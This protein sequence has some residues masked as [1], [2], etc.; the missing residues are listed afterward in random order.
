MARARTSWP[1][2][3]AL[4]VL[5]AGYAV[6]ECLAGARRSPLLPLLPRGVTA[7]GWTVRGARLLGLD[8]LGATALTA[9]GLVVMASLVAACAAAAIQAWRGR[10]AVAPAVVAVGLSLLLMVAG[11]VL[12]SRDVS[13]YAAY[14]RIAAVQGANP[15]RQTP[16]DFPNDPFVQAVSSEWIHSRSVYG[17]LFTLGSEAVVRAGTS[18][19][20]TVRWF[21]VLAAV[22]IGLA[23]WW[24]A[25]AA[26]VL[27]GPDRPP[28][29]AAAFAL[30]LVGLNPVLVVHTAGGAHNDALV[31][32]GLAGAALIAARRSRASRDRTGADGA[33][34]AVTAV[35]AAT[36]LIKVVAAIALVVW[37]WS[38][39]RSS[40]TPRRWGTLARHV[41][42]AV[43]LAVVSMVPYFDGWHTLGAFARLASRQ[44]WA[45]GAAMVARGASAIGGTPAARA[46]DVV[47]L[48]AFGWI[49]W[50]I[51]RGA[52]PERAPSDWAVAMLAFA[53]A[54]P[55]LLPWYAAWFV[56]L[57]AVAA[58]ARSP[59]PLDAVWIGAAASGVLALT[60]MPAEPIAGSGLYAHML[61]AV[62]Y[63]GGAVMLVLFVLLLRSVW[64]W[65]TTAVTAGVTT[66]S[67]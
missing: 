66:E 31:A 44:G 20:A 36:A 1:G 47:F 61:L 2:R 46:V 45:S 53:L 18:T 23:A 12:L 28:A 55:Y 34:L 25:A 13:S 22:G 54:A 51:L 58:S 35:L 60:G 26:R 50:R 9:V 49:L 63:A 17:P 39:V 27:A 15:Y 65:Q 19:A 21:Q 64:R 42:L 7:S 32:A 8:G 48:L 6:I 57:L 33:A 16:A 29:A 38:V 40:S 67:R 30:C 37:W 56:P 14:G 5:V 24:A 43:L 59:V 11:P 62:H 52:R 3:L 41:G 10:M 4:G